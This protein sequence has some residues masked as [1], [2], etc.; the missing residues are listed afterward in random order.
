MTIV[1]FSRM[2]GY[3]LDVAKKLA[4]EEG[5]D[6]EVINLRSLRPLDVD[7][8]VASI[9]KTNRL[10]TVEEGWPQSGVGS[11]IIA[12][13]NERKTLPPPVFF[14]S[15]H[16]LLS[17]GHRMEAV[18]DLAC[19]HFPPS[20]LDAFDYL[21]APPERI[22]GADVP[23]PYTPLLEDEAMVQPHNIANAVKRVCYRKI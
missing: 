8:I 5:I 19:F 1:T 3:A 11:E 17:S 15:T 2:V 23:M 4:E 13:A 9:K 12:V 7:T 6:A 16:S 20:S 21:D 10:V 14:F 22:T 18:P